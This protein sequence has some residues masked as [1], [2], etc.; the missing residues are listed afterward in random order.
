M[1]MVTL[2]LLAGTVIVCLVIYALIKGYDARVTLIGAGILMACIGGAPMSPLN[3]FAKSMT[4]SGLI[5]AVCSVMGFA[6]AV[7][8]TG[9]DKHLINAMASVISKVRFFLIPGVVIGTYLVNIALPSAAGTAAAA[10]AI[11]I[12][13]LMASGV[14]PALAAAAVKCGTYGSMLNPGL[15]HNPF[16]AK[17]A[18]VDVM[19]VIAFDYKAN[20][21]SLIVA[22]I[23][24]TVIAHVLKEDKGHVPEH[25]QIEKGFKVNPLYALMPVVPI[26]ILLLGST[27]LVPMFKMGVPQA[28]IIGTLL[29][30]VVTRTGPKAIGDAF[31]D[32]M[33]SAYG[34]IIGIIISAGV[35]VSGLTVIGL[36]KFF[37][38]AMLNNP[39]IIKICAALGPFLL[40]LLTGS[41]DAATF[42]FNEAITPH[43]ADFGMT[44]VQMGT[45][46]TLGGTLGRTMSPVAGATIICAGIA[47]INPMEITKRNA[48]P[49]FCA[50]AVGMFI[51][52]F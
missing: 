15:A 19:D 7:R 6:M 48:I 2:M 52:A 4:N 20:I 29:T 39:A 23:C 40:G 32:G 50:L 11:F 51:L 28:M 36:V 17:I 27:Q 38:D 10:G 34:K 1:E 44:S 26:V 35:F 12:P 8:Y 25:L 18:G 43:A 5:Q 45:M 37:I 16:V 14:G 46:A 22:T 13:L 49:M 30:L 9:C 41:G 42:A 24:I 3:A 31:F 21:A 33:G 47:G